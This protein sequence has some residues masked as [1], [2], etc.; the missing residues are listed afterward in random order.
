[1][2][3]DAEIIAPGVVDIV[4]D[5]GDFKLGQGRRAG[6]FRAIF[7]SVHGDFTFQSLA[8]DAGQFVFSDSQKICSGE[9]WDDALQAGAFV[10]VAV[11]AE[12]FVEDFALLVGMFLAGNGKHERNAQAKNL[13]P[14]FTKL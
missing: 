12:V 3:D 11:G 10:H 14:T 4:D 9:R 7:F 6:H 2:F 5:I 1:M 8:D 13:I